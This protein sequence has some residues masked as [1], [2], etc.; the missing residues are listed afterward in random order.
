MLF[1]RFFRKN[2]LWTIHQ[3][4]NN[5]SG[6]YFGC[7]RFRPLDTI[8]KPYRY[9]YYTYFVYILVSPQLNTTPNKR[10][11]RRTID[12]RDFKTIAIMIDFYTLSYIVKRVS[13]QYTHNVH[14][15]HAMY[16]CHAKLCTC[17]VRFVRKTCYEPS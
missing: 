17:R 4:V 13:L 14:I 2:E 16:T 3:R 6:I 12:N 9:F 1:G 5:N 10:I 15:S 7:F 11:T 8:I